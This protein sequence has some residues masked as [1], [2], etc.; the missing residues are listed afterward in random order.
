MIW[1][2][3]I[4]KED[5]EYSYKDFNGNNDLQTAW[6]AIQLMTTVVEKGVVIALIR[7]NHKPIFK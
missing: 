3:I 6:K 7:G 2:A 5:G 1:T 4:K